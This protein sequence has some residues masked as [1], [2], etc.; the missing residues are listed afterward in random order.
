MSR[1]KLLCA[2]NAKNTENGVD[3]DG[4]PKIGTEIVKDSLEFATFDTNKN[5]IKKFFHK[6]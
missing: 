4:I 1:F 6:D 5:E 3:I 2:S